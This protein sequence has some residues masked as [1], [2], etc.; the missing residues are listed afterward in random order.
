MNLLDINISNINDYKYYKI[1]CILYFIFI[2]IIFNTNI[3]SYIFGN[4]IS[5]I[6]LELFIYGILLSGLVFLIIYPFIK[7]KLIIL[8][9]KKNLNKNI[10]YDLL[11]SFELDEKT[12]KILKKINEIIPVLFIIIFIILSIYR[13]NINS[14]SYF[15]IA[16]SII[17]IIKCILNYSTILPDISEE[18]RIRLLNGGCNDLLCSGHF[19]IVLLIY[20]LIVKFKMIKNTYSN[21]LLI[22]TILYSII[23]VLSKNHYTIDILVSLI[24]V[25]LIN[26]YIPNK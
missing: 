26:K 19:S 17:F 1:V 6:E 23:P 4:N 3:L 16:I 15:L 24:L 12:K 8:S 7:I 20:L 21:Y 13:K 9:K 10:L 5:D 25:L 22:I 18:C 2:V 14:I 11:Q